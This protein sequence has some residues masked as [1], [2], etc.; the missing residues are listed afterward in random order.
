MRLPAGYVPIGGFSEGLAAVR[1]ASRARVGA[2]D[3]AGALIFS[4]AGDAL[5]PFS[6]GRAAFRKKGRF[7]YVDACGKIVIPSTFL[8]AEAFSDGLARVCSGSAEDERYVD[9]NGKVLLVG[10]E[11]RPR[12]PF[13][14]GLQYRL[15]KSRTISE[16]PNFRNIYGYRNKTGKYVWLSPGAEKAFDAAFWRKKYVG[17]CQPGGERRVK[18]L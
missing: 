18:S 1:R 16:R 6:Q 14:E 15:L 10:R 17:P 3:C 5:G 9:A 8:C 2:V 7:G 12:G 4:L 11:G 13:F